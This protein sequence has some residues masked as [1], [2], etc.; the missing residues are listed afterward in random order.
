MSNQ[1]PKVATHAGDTYAYGKMFD[2]FADYVCRDTGTIKLADSTNRADAVYG[3]LLQ[4]GIPEDR[5]QV[6]TA[7]ALRD[8]SEAHKSLDDLKPEDFYVES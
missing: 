7:F 1:Y 6:I 5:L 8:I 3:A 4:L 2:A